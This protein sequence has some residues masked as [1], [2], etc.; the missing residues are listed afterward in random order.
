MINRQ[1]VWMVLCAGLIIVSTCIVKT[2]S[3]AAPKSE[4]YLLLGSPNSG[5]GDPWVAVNPKDPHNIIVAAMVTL[6]RLPTGEAPYPRIVPFFQSIRSATWTSEWTQLRV[7]ELSVAD[8][9][10]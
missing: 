6:H 5:A 10:R 4:E 9:A 3:A 2:Q 7:E 1:C 8:T